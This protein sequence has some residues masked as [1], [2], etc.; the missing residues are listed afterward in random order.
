MAI[1]L[2][3]VSGK[4]AGKVTL[5]ALSTCGWCRMTREL[6]DTLGV[7]YY[8]VYADL[9]SDKEADEICKEVE[10]INPSSSFPTI[11]ID[12]KIIVGFKED[13]IKKALKR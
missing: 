13:D 5:Y 8:Y 7:E 2:K 1:K 11:K 9:A 10:R 6:L 3:H 12:G 4:K